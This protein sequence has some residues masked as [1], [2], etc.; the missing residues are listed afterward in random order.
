[1]S[2][3]SSVSVG[4]TPWIA[5]QAAMLICTLLLTLL[6]VRTLRY[7]PT[8]VVQGL[9]KPMMLPLH[10]P[11]AG[12]ADA[13]GR[14]FIREYWTWSYPGQVMAKRRAAYLCTQEPAEQVMYEAFAKDAH[15][16]KLLVTSQVIFGPLTVKPRP[17][18]D[19]FFLDGELEVREWISYVATKRSLRVN[20]ILGPS[21]NS[22]KDVPLLVAW[23]AFQQYGETQ[24]LSESDSHSD[25]DDLFTQ[26]ESIHAMEMSLRG[27][28]RMRQLL[29]REAEL[30]PVE[31]ADDEAES[32]I[33]PKVPADP[34][35]ET[36]PASAAPS[37]IST[38]E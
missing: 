4:K 37:P 38:K 1:M 12:Y 16:R 36:A 31:E 25:F 10:G 29:E 28:A 33:A 5:I 30:F 18:G 17:E 8:V 26:A 20:L 23:Y 7:G 9:A 34:R 15:L 14:R 3:F 32:R 27:A 11:D 19:S 2:N 6:A 24:S 21:D 35:V 22:D 13:I